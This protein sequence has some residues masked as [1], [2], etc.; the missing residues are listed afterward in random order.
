MKHMKYKLGDKVYKGAT[1]YSVTTV[2]CPDCLGTLEWIVTFADGESMIIG[3]QTCKQGFSAPHGYISYNE[4]K[5]CT[6]QLTIG[7]IYDW[8]ETDGFRYMCEET[9]IGSGTIHKES[10]LFIDKKDADQHSLNIYEEQM[11]MLARNNFSKKFNG[12]KAIEDMLS[13]FGYTRR[14]K[15]EKSRKFIRWAK[16]SGLLSKKDEA[17]K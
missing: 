12:K 1:D 7:K 6:R 15:V 3:C 16:I 9:G 13:T 11:K 4:W 17:T 14:E 10:E 5:P 8:N 2:S